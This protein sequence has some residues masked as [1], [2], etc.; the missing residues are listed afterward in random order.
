M[1]SVL[2]C[3]FKFLQVYHFKNR[4][5]CVINH[6]FYENKGKTHYLTPQLDSNILLSPHLQ[7][8]KK[9]PQTCIW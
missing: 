3:V 7:L 1:S 4:K 9:A 2:V 8:N 5:C 6:K